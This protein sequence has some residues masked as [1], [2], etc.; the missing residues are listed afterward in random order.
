LKL[1][2]FFVPHILAKNELIYVIIQTVFPIPGRC[3]RKRYTIWMHEQ[4]GREDR[5]RRAPVFYS[6]HAAATGGAD[7]KYEYELKLAKI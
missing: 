6:V 2:C 1:V 3:C 5:F 4:S 7:G